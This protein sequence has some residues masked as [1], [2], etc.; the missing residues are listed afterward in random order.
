MQPTKPTRLDWHGVDLHR[1]PP[2]N[3]TGGDTWKIEV[4]DIEKGMPYA[5][6]CFDIVVAEQILEHLRNPRFA[7]SEMTRITRPGGYLVIDVPIFLPPVAG[8]R[9]AYI[10]HLPRLFKFSGSGHLQTFSRHSIEQYLLA[11]ADLEIVHTE[12]FRLISGGPL[13]PLENYEWW[14]KS[15]VAMGRRYPSWAT[16]VQVLLRKKLDGN[17]SDK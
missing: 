7:I 12:G 3:R 6:G 4:A 1:L 13:R 11:E 5:D 2:E 8:L 17:L 15:S 9:N 16:E 10:R 14:Y